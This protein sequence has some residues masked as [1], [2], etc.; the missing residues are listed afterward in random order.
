MAALCDST[1][2]EQSVWTIHETDIIR[3]GQYIY[4]RIASGKVIPFIA[5]K[6]P[7]CYQTR[8]ILM[9]SLL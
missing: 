3:L 7:L 8:V 4:G 6:A 1:V 9:L 2:I 5:Y